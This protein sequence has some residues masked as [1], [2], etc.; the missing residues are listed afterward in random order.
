MERVSWVGADARAGRLD[1]RIT[2]GPRREESMT[3]AAIQDLYP[4]DVAHCYGCGRLN[5]EGLHVRTLWEGG[6]G[7][8]RFTP[9]P[10]HVAVP[11]IVYG[12]L[13][14]SLVDCHAIGT[15][16][17]AFMESAGRVP[18]RDP[19]PRFV[20]ASLRVEFLKPTPV[21]EELVLR[22]R[23][24]E[25]GERKVRVTAEIEAAGDVTVRGEVLAVRMP[26]SMG[27]GARPS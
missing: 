12:G 26:G 6:E 23:P 15:A 17:A 27:G 20:T 2:D 16:A 22:A 14:A 10:H 3:D 7:V 18:G 4:E 24:A 19:S 8:A 5:P 9:L 21:G 25:M 1:G 11:G 13:L